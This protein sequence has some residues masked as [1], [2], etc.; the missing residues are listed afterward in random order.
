MFA[1]NG[2]YFSEII[3]NSYTENLYISSSISP[4]DIKVF[5]DKIYAKPYGYI[6]EPTIFEV[7]IDAAEVM[8]AN[9]SPLTLINVIPTK[10]FRYF[11]PSRMFEEI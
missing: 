1:E 9:P 4:D 11:K 5:N 2:N 6:Y 8:D 7:N 10:I 3:D